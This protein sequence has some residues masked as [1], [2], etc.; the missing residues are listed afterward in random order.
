MNRMQAIA[1]IL[2]FLASH[3]IARAADS[4]GTA[5]SFATASLHLEQNATDGDYEIV[6]EVMAEQGLAKLVVLAPDGRAIIDF[7]APD[8]TELGMRQFRF[9]TPE[10]EDLAALKA[11]YPEGVYTFD[12]VTGG[13]VA[14]HGKSSLSHSVPAPSSVIDPSGARATVG[15]EDVEISR[16]PIKG[17]AGYIMEIDQPDLGINIT[18]KVPASITRFTVPD[19]VLRPGRKYTLAIGTVDKS[20]NASFIETSFTTRG[21]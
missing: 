13:G 7:K 15:L 5:N 2:F 6:V 21:K 3:G 12:G 19:A 10:P 9:E 14:L 1:G 18:T 20:G 17:A 16:T 11:V 8:G 4:T